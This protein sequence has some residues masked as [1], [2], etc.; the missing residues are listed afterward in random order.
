MKLLVSAC[1]LGCPCRYDGRSRPCDAVL[2]LREK[3]ILIPFCPEIYGGLPT[4]RPPAEIR[5]GSLITKD[6]REVTEAYEKG[7]ETALA[8]YDTLGC[9]G[10]ILKAKSPSCGVGLVYNGTF[11]GTLVPGDGVTAACFRARGI[12]ICTEECLLPM[13]SADTTEDTCICC[14]ENAKETRG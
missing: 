4:P 1:L 9:D 8:V 5:D 3:H 14:K 6:G 7:A 12:P 11:T 2:A 13:L 10:A